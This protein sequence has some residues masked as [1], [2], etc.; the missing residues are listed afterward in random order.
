MY[1]QAAV[2]VQLQ[3]LT[4]V[5]PPSPCPFITGQIKIELTNLTL[6]PPSPYRLIIGQI[7][8]DLI[9]LEDEFNSQLPINLVAASLYLT[10]ILYTYRREKRKRRT[11][12]TVKMT[13][14]LKHSEVKYPL[15][16]P[17]MY[18]ASLYRII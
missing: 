10:L 8:V 13:E 11:C 5:S 15:T 7:E 12:V 3:T 17:T 1:D 6:L 16:N 14:R 4:T 18:A 2:D 9:N